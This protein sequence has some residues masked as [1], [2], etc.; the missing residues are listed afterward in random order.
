MSFHLSAENIRVEDNHILRAR[1]RTEG[2]EWRDSEIDLDQHIGNTNGTFHWD[3]RGTLCLLDL[4]NNQ[5][6][7]QPIDQST[8]QPTKLLL[9]KQQLTIRPLN[10]LLSHRR[11][12]TLCHRRRRPGPRSP[13]KPLQ[14]GRSG[15]GQRRQLGRKNR[16][17]RR[18]LCL[19]LV[20]FYLHLGGRC[21][22]IWFFVLV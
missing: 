19:W 11:K 4:P 7:H 12:R 3:G 18:K 9:K 14:R 6:V 17:P 16:E 10:R 20:V 2:G 15:R 13:R 8:N 1:L 5:P 22:L 21:L